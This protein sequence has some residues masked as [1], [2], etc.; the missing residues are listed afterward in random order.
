MALETR[1]IRPYINNDKIGETTPTRKTLES[2][3]QRR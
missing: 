2:P 1:E 3:P